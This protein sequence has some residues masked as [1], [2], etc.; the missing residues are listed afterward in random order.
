MY[1]WFSFKPVTRCRTFLCVHAASLRNILLC[2]AG[3]KGNQLYLREDTH[4]KSV[5]LVVEPLRVYPPYT[6]VLVVHA[7]FFFNF[8][9]LII[10]WNGFWHFFFSP[11][12]GLKMQI[13]FSNQWTRE[14]KNVVLHKIIFSL[15]IFP[16][17]YLHL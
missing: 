16:V 10:A 8:F 7:T 5:F 4:K 1:S 2:V 13:L 12:F 11:I 9:S 15:C 3:L 6:N 14:M 17:N